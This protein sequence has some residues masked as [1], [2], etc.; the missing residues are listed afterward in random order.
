MQIFLNVFNSVYIEFDLSFLGHKG[1]SRGAGQQ[2]RHELN[3]FLSASI[4]H[5]SHVVR[6]VPTGGICY[7]PKVDILLPVASP[8]ANISAQN[9]FIFF[10]TSTVLEEVIGYLFVNLYL[11]AEIKKDIDVQD[12]FFAVVNWPN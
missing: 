9:L 7:V 4:H 5:P 12:L 8:T 10:M 1:S 6:F 2:I 3:Y 11:C